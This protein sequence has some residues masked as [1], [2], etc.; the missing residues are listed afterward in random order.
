[1]R[2][3]RKNPRQLDRRSRWVAPALEGDHAMMKRLLASGH[4]LNCGN[5]EDDRPLAAAANTTSFD[6]LSSATQMVR[7]SIARLP[8][9]APRWTRLPAGHRE[10]FAIGGSQLA[11]R[12]MVN[13]KM[14]RGSVGR[15]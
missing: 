7:T 12:E 8:A 15:D 10:D 1:M 14:G 13:G 9:V 11:G 5:E 4:D 6:P 3:C 2:D